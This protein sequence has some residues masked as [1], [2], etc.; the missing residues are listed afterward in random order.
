MDG[1]AWQLRKY[2]QGAVFEATENILHQAAPLDRDG[3]GQRP[4]FAG[5]LKVP[6]QF[7]TGAAMA[8]IAKTLGQPRGAAAEIAPQRR[9]PRGRMHRRPRQIR[10]QAHDPGRAVV[11]GD[12]K[13]RHAISRRKDARHRQA[14]VRRS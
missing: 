4:Q 5:V 7:V 14:G 13:L 12:V 10:Q 8:E 9:R 6:Q 1:L 2:R 11:E 3:V